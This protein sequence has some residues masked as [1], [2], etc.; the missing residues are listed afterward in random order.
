VLPETR[1]QGYRK[2]RAQSV[3]DVAADVA[4]LLSAFDDGL[5]P[6]DR[7]LDELRA[8]AYCAGCLENLKHR[9]ARIAATARGCARISSAASRTVVR[10]ED[11][12]ACQRV[13]Y[14][15]RTEPLTVRQV[16]DNLERETRLELATPTLA[17]SCSTN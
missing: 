8:L 4:A 10:R 5:L 12:R 16:L 1:L 6:L 11:A 3:T 17:R 2:L 7:L 13:P 15:F 9:Y 14:C